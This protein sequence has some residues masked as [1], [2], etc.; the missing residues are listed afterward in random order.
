MFARKL[1]PALAV[2][3]MCLV[4]VPS[5]ADDNTWT[6]IENIQMMKHDMDMM[7]K[8]MEMMKKAEAKKDKAMA[9]KAI[10][11]MKQY[12]SDYERIFGTGN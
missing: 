4:T 5:Y 2:G 1:F 7:K 11:M 3:L 6:S 12:I 8:A 10:E 9:M